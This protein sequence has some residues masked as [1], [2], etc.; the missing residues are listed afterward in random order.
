[1]RQIENKMVAWL[2]AKLLNNGLA[3]HAIEVKDARLLFRLAAEACVGIKETKYNAGPMVELL[4]ETV[5]T[6]EKESWCLSF[7]MTALAYAEKKT[8]IK[9]QI[10]ATEH[11][12]TCW[13]ESPKSCRVKSVP[14][15]GAI[16]IW[17]HGNTSSGHTGVM[18]AW[19]GNK[20]NSVEGNTSDASMRD[21]DGVFF[22][23][24]SST[25]TGSMKVV[26]FLKPF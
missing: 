15:P 23:T 21:G 12:M 25:A 3:Q 20:F 19:Q 16:V 6:A 1:M 18:V 7:V 24:R 2:D 14:A 8:G 17:R 13:N 9:S 26:G 10:A 11:C 22:K 4:Q 5:G